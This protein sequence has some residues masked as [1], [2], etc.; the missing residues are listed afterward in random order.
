MP[1]NPTRVVRADA[2]TL[3]TKVDLALNHLSILDEKVSLNYSRISSFERRMHSLEKKV[4][5]LIG[6]TLGTLGTGAVGLL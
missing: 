1:E 4:W 5:L 3:K 6:L 2:K